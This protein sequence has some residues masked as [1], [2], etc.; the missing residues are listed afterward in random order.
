[1]SQASAELS[2]LVH[3]VNALASEEVKTIEVLLVV[4]EEQSLLRCLNA[5]DSLEDR[6][7]ALLNPLTHRV[8][9]G[10]EVASCRED[11]LTVLTLRLAVKLLPPLAHV[12]K[13]RLK[14]YENLNLLASLCIESV[15]HSG[16]DSSRILSERYILTSS[17]LHVGSTANKSLDIEACNS[18][19]QQAD[20]C[21]NREATAYIVRNYECLVAFLCSGCTRSTLVSVGDSHDYVLCL[22]LAALIL[23]LL[24]EQTESESSLGSCARLRDIDH[25]ELLV[26]EIV[27]EFSE[28]I[29]A[30]IIA[31]ENDSW[32]LLVLNKPSERVAKRLNH[33]TSTEVAATDTRNHYHLALLAQCVGYALKLCD[34]L[35]CD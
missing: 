13:F 7:L 35:G 33:G 24:L 21:K 14:V 16:V 34:E 12:V 3:L 9:V 22:F 25:T 28:I 4:R 31:S 6:A 18:D 19:R 1:M 15:T 26:L 8:E 11:T 23:A 5:D 30:D 2:H 32:V 17:L 20:R 29:L 27:G 10:S